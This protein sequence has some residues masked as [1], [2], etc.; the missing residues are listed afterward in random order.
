MV[1]SSSE[2]HIGHIEVQFR[3]I[4]LKLRPP[5]VSDVFEKSSQIVLFLKKMTICASGPQNPTHMLTIGIP[6][7]SIGSAQRYLNTTSVFFWIGG[8]GKNVQAIENRFISR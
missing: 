1:N 7:R 5:K 2:S 4:T 3:E 8:I 6:N